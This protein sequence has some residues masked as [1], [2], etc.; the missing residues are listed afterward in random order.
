MNCRQCGNGECSTAIGICAPCLREMSIMNVKNLLTGT[1]AQSREEFNLAPLPLR[2]LEGISCRLCVAECQIPDGRW[3]WCGLHGN[4][5]GKIIHRAPKDT[6]LLHAY[7]DPQVTNCCNAWFCPAGTG[8]GYPEI[9]H[10]PGPEKG[11]YNLAL[12]FYGCSFNCLFCQN[13]QHKELDRA[14]ITSI[15]DI[16][17][18]TLRNQKISCWCWFGGS[19]EPQLSFTFK[20]QK[21]LLQEKKEGRIV[22]F[23]YE[24]NGD[25]NRNTALRA[26]KYSCE[27]GGNVKFD[28][29]AWNPTTH[30][31]LTGME[32]QRVLENI[33]NLIER[34]W[35]HRPIENPILGIS[36]LLVPYYVGK[37]EIEEIAKF[38][39]EFDKDIPYSLLV[40]HPD[41]KMRDLPVTP[42][43]QVKEC[44][45]I[46]K[47]YLNRVNVGNQHLL[48][49]S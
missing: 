14:Q 6:A 13:W 45:K 35:D 33:T 28:F 29:K 9:S 10:T 23:C 3:G 27:S 19:P 41:F 36:T 7:L 44:E 40:F 21:R 15:D 34:H 39:S 8:C 48:L 24:W 11:Y 18:T 2:D 37:E 38:L 4:R 49:Y 26:A 43:Q 12:F 42:L 16:V 30:F 17:E 31:A 5:S 25:G 1:H 22:R 32:N 20:A 47:K 46:A